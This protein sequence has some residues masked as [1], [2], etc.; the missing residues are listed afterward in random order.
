MELVH[1]NLC[2]P[3]RT[4]SQSQN[5][6][7][8]LFIDDLSR[9]TWV[10]FL[11]EK[12]EAFEI[13][14]KFILLVENQS[15]K[16]LKTLRSDRGTEFNSKKFDEFCKNEGLEHQL[17]V[18]YNP[19]QNGVSERK[20]RTIMEMA[21][22]MLMAKGLPKKFWAKAVNTTV[23]LL[24]RC[25][26]KAVKNLTPIEAWS[27]IKPTA[28]HLKVFGRICY[29]HILEQK[30]HKLEEKSAKGVFLGYSS[31]S[32]G[33]RVF[34]LKSQQLVTSR[35]V[36]FDEYSTWNWEKDEELTQPLTVPVIEEPE[37]RI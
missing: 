28:E 24:N 6:Y 36:V 20:N 32:K 29:M 22:S 21:R 14:K 12:S 1:T 16:K 18:A 35:D 13:F 10:Y 26:T 37:T 34:N 7:F 3:M 9:M 23:Y 25:P 31:Q 5:K 19:Q 8:I 2:G 27:A 15:G 30:R 17:T 11:K 4:P 33:Y